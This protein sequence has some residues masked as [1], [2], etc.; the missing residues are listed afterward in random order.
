MYNIFDQSEL[1]ETFINEYFDSKVYVDKHKVDAKGILAKLD[2]EKLLK[3]DSI[4][5][6]KLIRGATYDNGI[7]NQKV[8]HSK[9]EALDL[10][11]N[12]GSFVLNHLNRILDENHELNQLTSE[13]RSKFHCPD[14]SIQLALFYTA[15]HGHGFAPHIDHNEFFVWQLAGKKKWDL[16]DIDPNFERNNCESLPNAPLSQ[17]QVEPGDFLYIPRHTIHNVKNEHSEPSISISI[18]MKIPS[19]LDFMLT[20][21]KLLASKYINEKNLYDS[22]DEQGKRETIRV[23]DEFFQTTKVHDLVL[24][25]YNKDLVT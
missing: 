23:M 5:E 13:L 10:Y 7:E 16:Y 12:Q 8:I 1:F 22:I 25:K 17:I 3:R 15:P 9:Q 11:A 19:K 20:I 24:R 21:F 14:S 2:I 6:K 18:I 4:Y